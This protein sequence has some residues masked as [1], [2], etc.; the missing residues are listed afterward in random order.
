G[1]RAWVRRGEPPPAQIAAV[2]RFMRDVHGEL[3]ADGR[4]FTHTHVAKDSSGYAVGVYAQT[5]EL[6]DLLAGSEGTLALFTSMELALM[7]AAAATA[8]LFVSFGSLDA[9]ADAAVAARDAGAAACELLDRTFL[10]IAARAGRPLP[11]SAG[12]D[13]AL[14]VEVEAHDSAAAAAAV[15][16]LDRLFRSMGADVAI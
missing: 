2:A 9:A 12:A 7:P 15:N 13:A 6:I 8:S 5:Q 4:R 16:D 10:V 14:L 11:A 3:L 1:S